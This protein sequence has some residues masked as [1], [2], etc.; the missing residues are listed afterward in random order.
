MPTL[1]QDHADVK[2]Y[3][4]MTVKHLCEY[5][6]KTLN[7]IWRANRLANRK[8]ISNRVLQSYR[9]REDLWRLLKKVSPLEEVVGECWGFLG[10]AFVAVV[11][12]GACM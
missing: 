8:C 5:N 4:D 9:S 1:K 10:I 7:V 6:I 11:S 12:K 3:A 2:L